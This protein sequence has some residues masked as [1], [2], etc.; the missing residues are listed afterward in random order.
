MEE[1]RTKCHG[2]KY[3]RRVYRM[4]KMKTM[5]GN[6]AAAHVAYAFT[7]VATIYP[8]TPSSTMAEYVDS[9]A[10]EGRKNIFGQTVKVVEMQLLS[11]IESELFKSVAVDPF[12]VPRQLISP[13]INMA[14][15][16]FVTPLATRVFSAIAQ[17]ALEDKSVSLVAI[18]QK[19]GVNREEL[20]YLTRLWGD[21]K[22]SG[23]G[24]IEP[25]VSAMQKDGMLP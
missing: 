3:E 6:C 20:L 19:A 21:G 25:I 4:K 18:A 15:E 13:E 22:A 12:V 2:K 24:D 9:W 23:S 14:G 7:E 16:W 5:D 1:Q 8:I 17:I 10:A 11:Q